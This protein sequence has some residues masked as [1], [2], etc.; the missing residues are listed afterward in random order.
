MGCKEQKF[1]P[2]RLK[3]LIINN[4]EFI[5]NNKKKHITRCELHVIQGEMKQSKVLCSSFTEYLLGVR[6]YRVTG[7]NS[8]PYV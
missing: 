1:T 8:S 6:H 2:N 4:A 7:K 5:S 3:T